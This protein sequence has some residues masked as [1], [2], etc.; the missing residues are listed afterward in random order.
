[1]KNKI[2]F[3]FSF[4]VV[5]IVVFS[6]NIKE[7]KASEIL[8]LNRK[9][10]IYYTRYGGGKEYTSDFYPLYDIGGK[11][12]YCIEPGVHLTFFEYNANLGMTLSPYDAETNRI[13]QLIGH[14]GY[15]YPGHDDI[16]YRM[17]TQ[18]LIWEK[19]GGQTVEFYTERYGYGLEID[20]SREK[21]EIM[22]LVNSH[23][24]KPDFSKTNFEGYLGKE[25]VLEDKNKVLDLFEITSKGNNNVKKVGNKL[26]ITPTKT[27][28]SSIVFK[29]SRY[30]SV[31]TMIFTAISGVSQKLAV[32]R[33]GE[34]V[35]MSINIKAEGGTVT[36]EKVDKDTK[37]NIPLGNAIL[38]GAIYGVY[39]SKNNLV[40]KL[41]TNEKGLV[42]SKNLNIG[43]YTL[44]EITPSLGYELDPTIYNFEI[45]ENNL[46]PKVKVYE[47]VH[48]SNVDIYK[49]LK[50]EQEE[51][52]GE[53]NII[54]EI[55][56]KGSNKVYK[57][58][59]TDETGHVKFKL[60]YGT[61][62]FKQKNTTKNYQKVPDFEIT[63]NY[64]NKDITK[65]L[66]D[67]PTK[68]KLR[69]IKID[70][71]TKEIIPKEGIKFKIK[72]LKTNKYICENKDC[73]FITNKEGEV[74]TNTEL[75]G[76]YEIEEVNEKVDGYLWNNKK[77]KVKIDSSTDYEKGNVVSVQFPNNRVKGKVIIKK[78][79]EEIEFKNNNIT[80]K[81]V[82][83]KD[84]SF[85]LYA[86]MDIY[87][88][89]TLKY[90]KGD[91]INTYKTDKNGQIIIKDLELGKYY[92]KETKTVLGHILDTKNH[93]FELKYKDQY[94]ELVTK[95]INLENYLPKGELEFFKIDTKTR[96]YL[97]D[98]LIEVYKKE[99]KDIL[100]Y[101][102][103]T[104]KDGK[105]VLE[106]LP[107]GEY[108]IKEVKSPEGYYLSDEIINFKI[109]KNKQV[110]SLE[111]ENTKEEIPVPK[112][113]ANEPLIYKILSITTFILGF[114]IIVLVRKKLKY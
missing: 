26:Y 105:I 87:V 112:T 80:Y 24:V 84:V 37:L 72:D 27:G 68:A 11:V 42:T 107:L 91:L 93:Y 41:T 17:A 95:T 85:S 56:L 21:N 61:Y 55:Y 83:L 81:K 100:I 25:I 86:N 32:L 48:E 104:S 101:Q 66:Y 67:I 2:S 73:Y 49:V 43:K 40:T 98:A 63:I 13:L 75:F 45:T 69:I 28:T 71:E 82:P 53:A 52:K 103:L 58:I 20:V 99:K 4:L 78:S 3:F 74:T 18:S 12:A 38:K 1:M 19:T 92:I 15:E 79:G 77:I 31:A 109:T 6:L 47:K 39:D 51:L 23:N 54:F 8:T 65:T 111:M 102:G 62:T 16:R 59:K 96:T 46:N 60:P 94:E 34:D 70:S 5:M 44:K 64:D 57:T 14:Y 7:I 110:I 88:G 97:K 114:S 10:N 22:D 106:N 36:V 29:K 33:S 76:E 9:E 108:Y 30:D 35:K 90:K 113:D 50:E 89:K